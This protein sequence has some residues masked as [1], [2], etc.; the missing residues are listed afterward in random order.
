M[1]DNSSQIP[2]HV[3]TL[4]SGSSREEFDIHLSYEPNQKA[5]YVASLTS[6]LNPVREST[7]VIGRANNYGLEESFDASISLSDGMFQLLQS[8]KP[9]AKNLEKS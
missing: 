4:T 9:K 2:I 3:S 8:K 7:P 6:V 1:P 5:L